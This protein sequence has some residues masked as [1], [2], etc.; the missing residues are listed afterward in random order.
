MSRG[1]LPG[2]HSAGQAPRL[3]WQAGS[4][5]TPVRDP[6]RWWVLA[7]AVGCLLAVGVDTGTVVLALPAVRRALGLGF[8][9]V[10][11]VLAVPALTV[12][13]LL[14]P[15]AR[16]ARGWGTRRVL[17]LGLLAV[18]AGS[19]SAAAATSVPQLLAARLLTGTGAAAVLPCALAALLAAFDEDHR[20]RGLAIWAA[21]S[22]LLLV[23]GPL[24]GGLLLR[25]GWRPVFGLAAGLAVV[26]LALSAWRVPAATAVPTVRFQPRL[27]PLVVHA[28]LAGTVLLLSFALQDGRRHTAL[29]AALLLLPLTLGLLLV[30]PRA[31]R[32][33]Q[34]HSRQR[35][36]REGL[37]LSALALA[38]HALAGDPLLVPCL[39]LQGVGAALVVAAVSSDGSRQLGTVL[40]VLTA[41]F[42]L[43]AAHRGDLRVAALV[44]AG[45]LAAAALCISRRAASGA[46]RDAA[47]PVRPPSEQRPPAS[48]R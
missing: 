34:A 16:L 17:V 19:A 28:G 18:A 8:P 5:T 45:C 25:H 1:V 15:A 30:G 38:G 3:A 14:A 44:A 24:L 26:A 23:L 9:A 40:G 42:A 20:E 39:F 36:A 37:L 48:A 2:C 21:F 41:A 46:A 10:T 22:G 33:I 29:G 12:G 27:A 43:P 4:V 31:D 7:A 35:V 13:L 6:R 47:A 32:R 11:A